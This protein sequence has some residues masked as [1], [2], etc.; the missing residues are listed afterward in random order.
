VE[1]TALRSILR[2]SRGTRL[3]S[4]DFAAEPRSSSCVDKWA[5][6]DSVYLLFFE[7]IAEK[8]GA[9]D[10]VYPIFFYGDGRQ[11]GERFALLHGFSFHVCFSSKDALF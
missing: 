9:V 2:W 10:F 11:M 3:V 7:L 8:W 1:L 4:F 6:L 5:L